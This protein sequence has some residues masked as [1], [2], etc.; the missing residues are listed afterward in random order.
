MSE[1]NKIRKDLYD[2]YLTYQQ[3]NH[4][5]VNLPPVENQ[6]VLIYD[7]DKPRYLVGRIGFS[8]SDDRRRIVVYDS[9]HGNI[10]SGVDYIY[11]KEFEYFNE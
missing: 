1:W 7:S 11:W 4:N 8:F 5:G 6:P 2:P 3:N 9:I 10:Y